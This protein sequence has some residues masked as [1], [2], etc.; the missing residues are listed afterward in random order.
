MR[1]SKGERKCEKMREKVYGDDRMKVG[2]RRD[3]SLV[4]LGLVGWRG[5][6]LSSSIKE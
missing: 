1:E 4:L 2:R 3:I 5:V 6:L